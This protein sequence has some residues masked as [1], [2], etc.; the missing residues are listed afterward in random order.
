MNTKIIV[1]FSI[2]T[3]ICAGLL[4]WIMIFLEKSQTDEQKINAVKSKEV[5]CY[6]IDNE[7]IDS[8]FSIRYTND[9]IIF[10]YVNDN[11][12]KSLEFNKDKKFKRIY[13]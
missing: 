4:T 13:K 1:K 10:E 6:K 11:K 5:L 3:F 2:I 9:L 8:V 7:E 12:I